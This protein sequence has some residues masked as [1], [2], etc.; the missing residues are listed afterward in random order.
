MPDKYD[1]QDRPLDPAKRLTNGGSLRADA[2]ALQIKYGGLSGER[3]QGEALPDR[4]SSRYVTNEQPTD[5]INVDGNQE[6][7]GRVGIGSYSGPATPKSYDGPGYSDDY[8]ASAGGAAG[9]TTRLANRKTHGGLDSSLGSDQ[10]ERDFLRAQYDRSESDWRDQHP[11]M[12]MAN[13]AGQSFTMAQSRP[14]MRADA[15][16]SQLQMLREKIAADASREHIRAGD[17]IAGNESAAR[18]RGADAVTGGLT[19]SNETAKQRRDRE[20]QEYLAA[21]PLREISGKTG[22][23]S[24]QREAELQAINGGNDLADAK[25]NAGHLP[26]R[27]AAA[28]VSK[29]TPEQLAAMGPRSRAMVNRLTLAGSGVPSDLISE[30]N[31]P[32]AAQSEQDFADTIEKSSILAAD[33]KKTL[34]AVDNAGTRNSFATGMGGVMDAAEKLVPGNT[35]AANNVGGALP[36]DIAATKSA[37]ARMAQKLVENQ[38]APDTPTAT[39]LLVDKLIRDSTTGD[40]KAGKQMHAELLRMAQ[41]LAGKSQL[42][43]MGIMPPSRLSN[44]ATP[45]DPH[46]MSQIPAGQKYNF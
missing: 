22:L 7:R 38:I 3:S 40:T 16:M 28:S 6:T 33:F 24:A 43:P 15:A 11:D 17:T 12:T 19:L 20:Q 23:A 4:S 8:E 13:G 26:E 44:G 42:Q 18:I 41:E 46:G 10:S 5:S 31:K 37:V 45:D 36:V 34:A 39:R 30:L 2:L 29:F 21:A 35:G 9:S 25:Y 27:R 1:D 14:R 32:M